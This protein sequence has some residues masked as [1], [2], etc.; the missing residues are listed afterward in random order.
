M[1]YSEVYNHT[2]ARLINTELVKQS[3]AWSY[4]KTKARSDLVF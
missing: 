3:D 2:I 1:A 4:F